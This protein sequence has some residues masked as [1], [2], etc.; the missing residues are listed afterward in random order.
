MRTNGVWFSRGRRDRLFEESFRA[1]IAEAHAAGE[2]GELGQAEIF[3]RKAADAIQRQASHDKNVGISPQA[4]ETFARLGE[5]HGGDGAYTLLARAIER[6]RLTELELGANAPAFAERLATLGRL[7]LALHGKT[8][9][10]GD[11]LYLAE[12][13]SRWAEI[14]ENLEERALRIRQRVLGNDHPLAADSLHMISRFPPRRWWP[15]PGEAGEESGTERALN[16]RYDEVRNGVRLILAYDAQSR[17]FNGTVEN[18]TDQMLERVRVKVHL[19]SG[20]VLG[21]TTP[22]DLEPGRTRDVT[23]M[24]TNEDFDGW[25]AHPEVGG[26]EHGRGDE[27]GEHDRE[28]RG[29]H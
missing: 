14:G 17:S 5:L 28:G 27:H 21:P 12:Q 11:C 15:S 9:G 25:T 6:T 20:E 10:V 23:L 3:F 16:E 24:A 19:S 22:A 29:E 7:Y 1:Q 8:G 2:R 26:G 4:A 18:T 13:R